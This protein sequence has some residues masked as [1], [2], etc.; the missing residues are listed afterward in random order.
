MSFDK[1]LLITC[2]YCKKETL[3]TGEK[4]V[5]S[6]NYLAIAGGWHVFRASFSNKNLHLCTKCNDETPI[7]QLVG[8]VKR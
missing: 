5:V 4:D 8:A 6:A 7:T 1:N 2:D 3:D